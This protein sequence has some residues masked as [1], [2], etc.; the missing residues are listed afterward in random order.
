MNLLYSRYSS[1]LLLAA[2]ITLPTSAAAVGGALFIKG[3]SMFLQDDNQLFDTPTHIPV[4]VG[5]NNV[6]YRV[7]DLGWELRFRNGWAVGTEYLGYDHRFTPTASPSAKGVA[8]TDAFMVNAKKYIFNSGTFHP[9]V[10]AGIGIAFTDISNNRSGGSIDDINASL[11]AHA[12]LGIELR[13]DYLSFML[14]AKTLYSDNSGNDVEY[15]PT[16]S[17]L[18]LG[19]GFNW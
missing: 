18:L 12:M 4:T 17:G 10:G 5:L 13:V 3:G 19:A 14:E 15:N 7:I 9:Y 6:S 1:I 8:L 16:A 2:I 11:I